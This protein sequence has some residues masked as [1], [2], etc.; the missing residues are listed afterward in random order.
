[1]AKY[2]DTQKRLVKE[3]QAKNLWRMSVTV[4]ISR[5]KAIEAYCLTHDGSINKTMNRLLREAIGMT[6]AEWKAKG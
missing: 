2:S 1:M 4:P 5:R 6:E 3:Y